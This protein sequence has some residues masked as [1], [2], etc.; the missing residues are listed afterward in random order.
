MAYQLVNEDESLPV[1]SL[2][3]VLF[4]QP[5]M[6]K[7]SLSYT[8]EQP[9]LFDFDKGAHRAVGRKSTIVMESWEDCINVLSDIEK[10]NFPF[11]PKTII[12]DTAGTMLD[13]FIAKYAVKQDFKNSKK[14]GELSLQGYGALKTISS[15]FFSRVKALNID[16]IF[17]CHTE[18]FKDG[19]EIKLRPKMTGGSYDI[20]ISKADMVGYMESKNNTRTLNFNPTDRHIGKNTAEIDVLTIPHYDDPEFQGYM[21]SIIDRTKERIS[22]KSEAQEKAIRLLQEYRIRIDDMEAVSESDKE[23]YG[24]I[25]KLSPTYSNQ[26]LKLFDDKY[27]ENWKKRFD[28]INDVDELNMMLNIYQAEVVEQ[29][30]KPLKKFFTEVS[31]RLNAEFDKEAKMY[32]VKSDAKSNTA[33][34][35]AE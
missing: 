4:G 22:T 11:I 6:S 28:S 25:I 20:L 35:S 9:L 32:F 29:Y 26:L 7:T 12:T 17:I 30:T 16:L 5:G 2:V 10:G 34:A 14:G 27:R 24:D 31:K 19:D 3:V 8:S 13:D 33:K 18:Q 15:Q 23:L 21:A 1:N